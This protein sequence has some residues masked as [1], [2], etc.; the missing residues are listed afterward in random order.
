LF[1]Y[2][3]RSIEPD[4]SKI[5]SGSTFSAISKSQI[6]NLKI[7]LPPLETQRRIASYLKEK[8]SEIE[9][10][11]SAILNQKSEID[12]LPQAILRKAFRGEL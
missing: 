1:F 2:Y 3:L 11:K 6:Y 8:M 7:P 10:L 4:V 12:A 5:G 9:K